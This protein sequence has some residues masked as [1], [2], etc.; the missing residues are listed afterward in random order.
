M[1]ASFGHFL[2]IMGD[3]RQKRCARLVSQWMQASRENGTPPFVG[4][5]RAP[6]PEGVFGPWTRRECEIHPRDG[7]VVLPGHGKGKIPISPHEANQPPKA[8][9]RGAC[10]G[11]WIML[12]WVLGPSYGTE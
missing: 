9:G 10:K 7:S 8:S 12:K 5:L 4:H 6:P 3:F 11:L 1:P 2:A